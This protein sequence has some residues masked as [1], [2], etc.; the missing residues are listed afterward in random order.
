MTDLSGSSYGRLEAAFEYRRTSDSSCSCRPLPWSVA[1]QARHADYALEAE[2]KAIAEAA[3]REHELDAVA[4]RVLAAM[5]ERQ[6]SAPIERQP[7]PHAVIARES[8]KEIQ[9]VVVANISDAAASSPSAVNVP[10]A[11]AAHSLTPF[12]D[13]FSPEPSAQIPAEER[14]DKPDSGVRKPPAHTTAGGGKVRARG[15]SKAAS[16]PNKSTGR[17]LFQL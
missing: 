15:G 9:P 10:P 7:V 3:Q 5:N 1:E 4:S 6:P 17:G 11:V 16:R 2:N 13:L 12:I 14:S 8:A